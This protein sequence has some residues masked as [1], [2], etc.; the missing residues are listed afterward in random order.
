MSRSST[1]TSNR[2]TLIQVCKRAVLLLLPLLLVAAFFEVIF[3]RARECWSATQVLKAFD[4]DP[5][6]LYGPRFFAPA[7]LDIRLARLRAGNVKVLALGS[8]RVT[9]FRAPMFAP[10]QNEFLNAG[11]MVGSYPELMSALDRFNQGKLPPPKVL[12]LGIDPWWM[13]RGK[14]RSAEHVPNAE[15]D[16]TISAVSHLEAMRRLVAQAS[17]PWEVLRPGFSHKDVFYGY[18]AIGLGALSGNCY[19]A[20]GSVQSC[21]LIADFVKKGHYRDRETP[22]VIERIR[23]RTQ[24]FGETPGIDW[25]RA[26]KIVDALLSLKAKGSEIYCFLPPF[27]TEC[28]EAFQETKG[29]TVWYAEYHAEFLRRV[30]DAGIV[31]L[32]VRS[33]TTYGLTDDYM[34]DG[35]HPGDVFM[36]YVVEDLVHRAPAGS[37]LATVD[38]D[39]LRQLRQQPGVIPISLDPPPSLSSK[40]GH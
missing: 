18:E 28:D 35:F 1:S 20:D 34:I 33:P 22:P 37:T 23:T 19:R 9:Q 15:N 36:T 4:R 13:K 40:A 14:E 12:I 39:H 16:R 2:Q 27:S 10:M 32:D 6:T 3:W 8:S 25:K 17:I 30:N 21:R 26:D 38:L 11:L 31:C 29:L 24:R 7:L 5:K